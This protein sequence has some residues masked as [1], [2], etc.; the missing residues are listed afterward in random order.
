M[1]GRS[2]EP[3]INLPPFTLGLI[4]AN[5]LIFVVLEL[6]PDETQWLA[7]TTFGFVP[8][9]FSDFAPLSLAALVCPFTY[10]FLHGDW[11]HLL[12]N[13]VS[14]AAFG[15]GVE[16]QVGG[17]TMVS[18]FLLCGAIAAAAH[19]AVYPQSTEP[20]IGASGSIA[21]L[22]AGALQ[23]LR[24]T[25]AGLIRIAIVSGIA[26]FA[27]GI[28]GLPG[29]DGTQ[30]AWVAHIGGFAGGLALFRIFVGRSPE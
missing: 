25:R 21:G 30:I 5:T 9:R 1:T 23:L 14:L 3:A 7:V 17:G 29:N 16:R 20:V 26:M 28:T 18:V 6:S 12:V 22:M 24:S 8:G 2:S 11:V 27:L 10:Q 19:F 15:A 13:M 4:V